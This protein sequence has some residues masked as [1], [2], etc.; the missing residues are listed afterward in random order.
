MESFF[1]ETGSELDAALQR[2]VAS[3]GKPADYHIR[4]AL[5]NYLEDM[6]DAAIAEERIAQSEGR[7]SSEEL[8]VSLGL[9]D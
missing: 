8:R 6:R 3:S 7:M 9:D 5:E 4:R 2:L 1:T